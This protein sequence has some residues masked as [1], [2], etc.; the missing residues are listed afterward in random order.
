M[1][2][3]IVVSCGCQSAGIASALEIV[4]PDDVIHPVPEKPSAEQ[5]RELVD[6]IQRSTGRL[7][8]IASDY[9][10]SADDPRLAALGDA[11]ELIRVP[12]IFFRGFHPDTTY[13]TN[14]AGQPIRVATS[15][16]LDLQQGWWAENS[17]LV[18]W[19]WRNR[20]TVDAATALFNADVFR[21]L[22]YFDAWDA[23][24]RR[25]RAQFEACGL[26][27]ARFFQACKQR[28]PFMLS[29]N[30]PRVRALTELAKQI[31]LK[32]DAPRTVL[33]LPLDD[34]VPDDLAFGPLWPIYTE[35][36]E[37]L[38]Y[39]TAYIWRLSPHVYV[40]GV[41]PYVA[42]AYASYQAQRLDPAEIACHR[43]EGGL[44]DDALRARL[45]TR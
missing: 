7:I 30:H 28:G 10:R 20:L 1:G 38:G 11:V 9:E 33:E 36:G 43:F 29:I 4:F 42:H 15:P 22:G 24:V 12:L 44:F 32:L 45:G 13:A 16:S 41:A 23:S 37:A 25:L 6:T 14:A 27:F 39:K 5:T 17:A 2:R 8:W 18:L 26:D 19:A 21:A 3:L 34:L 40:R 31:A 35:I